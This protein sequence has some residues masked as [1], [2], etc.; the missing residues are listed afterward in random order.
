MPNK[1]GPRQPRRKLL[2]SVATS[3]LTYGIV[4]WG[5]ALMIEKYRR[6]MAAGMPI[7][8]LAVERKQLYEQRSC[9]LG[10]R[11][12]LKK[13]MRQDSLQR[14]QEKLDISKKGR[15]T[16]RLTPQVDNWVNRKHGEVN[17]YLT[18]MLSNHGCFRAY[19]YRFRHDESPECPAGCRVPEDTEYVF[20]WCPRFAGERKEL[21]E[22]LGSWLTPDSRGSDVRDGGKLDRGQQFRESSHENAARRRAGTQKNEGISNNDSSL[23]TLREDEHQKSWK[24]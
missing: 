5:E 2:A 20:F 23:T 24:S 12:E 9:I 6:K 4:I 15:W 8:I 11:K 16:H 21:E 22:R 10:G 17:Y 7:E 19:L 1:G 13:I 3:I 14:W 18:Q